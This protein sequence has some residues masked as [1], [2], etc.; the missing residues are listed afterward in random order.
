MAVPFGGMK[1]SGVGR[2]E[3]LEE[4]LDYT[5]IKTI[6]IVLRKPRH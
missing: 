4:M 2:E 5:E 3:G 1:S 6:N